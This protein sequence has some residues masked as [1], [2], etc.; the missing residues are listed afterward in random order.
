MPRVDLLPIPRNL[1]RC[2]ERFSCDW[3]PWNWHCVEADYE[4]KVELC[5]LGHKYLRN[6][7]CLWC[8]KEHGT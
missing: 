6:L 4:P 7:Y 1:D 2:T 5:N 3:V 8:N